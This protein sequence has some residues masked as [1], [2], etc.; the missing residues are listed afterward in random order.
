M[1]GEAEC[2]ADLEMTAPK[3]Q[4][5]PPPHLHWG[6]YGNTAATFGKKT[7]QTNH[8]KKQTK[9]NQKT[10]GRPFCPRD[11]GPAIPTALG[12]WGGADL[13][14]PIPA[15]PRGITHTCASTR[16]HAPVC[17][18][19]LRPRRR[20]AAGS[21]RQGCS[22]WVAGVLAGA[23]GWGG[24]GTKRCCLCR[25]HLGCIKS[26]AVTL[27]LRL[28]DPEMTSEV[29]LLL[30][31]GEENKKKGTFYLGQPAWAAGLC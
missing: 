4:G 22:F 10:S 29:Q 21:R 8:K 19:P 23:G 20:A 14:L 9:T 12:R 18:Q 5:E 7:Q 27:G 30:E 16:M 15:L 17:R 13:P 25:S 2:P 26:R 6:S 1:N 28:P 24:A 31:K 3:N 11:G